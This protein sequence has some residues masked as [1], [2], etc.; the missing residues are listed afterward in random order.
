MCEESRMKKILY[1]GDK[2]IGYLLKQEYENVHISKN[3]WSLN[4]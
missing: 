3:F 1:W 4:H 2:K